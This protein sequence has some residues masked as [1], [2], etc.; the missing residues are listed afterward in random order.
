MKKNRLIYT[1][2][3]TVAA[4]ILSCS[5]AFASQAA[6]DDNFGGYTYPDQYSNCLLL[7]GVDVSAWQGEDVDWGKVKRQGMDY[8]FIRIGY[9]SLDTFKMNE[10]SCFEIN[11]QAARDANMMVG[12]YYYSCATTMDEAQQEAEFVLDTLQERELDLPVVF[13]FEYAGRIKDKYKSKA[14]TTSN[15]LAFLNYIDENSE[16]EPM[17]YSYRNITD[18]TWSP[19]FNVEM[20]DAKYKVWL[21]QYSEDI[22]YSRPMTFWQ[23]TSSGEVKGIDGNVDCNFWFY[24]NDAEVTV[25]GTI[26]IKDAE[27]KLN[28]LDPSQVTYEYTRYSKRPKTTVFYQGVQLTNNVDFK[29]QFVKNVNV[30]TAYVM[31][32][33]IGAY[34][35]TKLV[36]YTITPT[37]IE[38]GIEVSA[39]DPQ[40]FT[41]VPVT[42]D[43]KV[44]YKGTTLKNGV[45]YTLTYENNAAVG[46][47]TVTING[48]RNYTGSYSTTFDIL[49]M[50]AKPVVTGETTI[51]KEY[52]SGP[53]PLGLTTTS[54]GAVTYTSSNPAI[55]A[56]GPDGTVTL[57]GAIGS[58]VLTMSTEANAE[59]YASTTNVTLNVTKLVNEITGIE[60]AYT[61]LTDAQPFTLG[62]VHKSTSPMTFT[63]SNPAVAA[64]D[65]AGLITVTGPG[66][67]ELTYSVA[68]DAGYLAASKTVIL[69]VNRTKAEIIQCIQASTIKVSSKAAYGK[70]TLTWKKTGEE[71]VD[72]YQ[73]FRTKKK[74]QFYKTAFGKT[75]D[76]ATLTF[77]N[78][79]QLVK[80]TR[81]YY[82][83][84]G[85]K[86]IDG[87][88]YYTKWSN[89]ANRKYTYT[90]SNDIKIINGIK[91]TTVKATSSRGKGYIKINWKKTGNY[92][93]DYYQICRSTTKDF[94]KN[95]VY[96][97]T[98]SG[99][100]LTNKHTKNL[101]KGKRYYYKVRGV[102]V[103]DGKKRFTQW[104]NVVTRIAK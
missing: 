6:V 41:G 77:V 89:V 45:D 35:N 91:A 32:Q 79:K 65:A 100:V 23:Y 39:I 85:V 15:I 51:N 19:K 12:V 73:V 21:A 44:S 50:Q 29:L 83:V 52:I 42:V 9:T 20:I 2:L 81:Y 34:S 26:N 54:N 17:F 30:G 61:V 98:K 49:K 27:V 3:L 56:I 92:K 46:T 84:R 57:T 48:M 74:G 31:V 67:T 62:A 78:D 40:R 8:A 99:K 4:L 69:T 5:A 1:L 68:E 95:K 66:Q 13:D 87:K 36:P 7:D 88:K 25:D 82:K 71:D 22:G 11:Y 94:S 60:P 24:N 37:D 70:V 58:V 76:A 64:I 10:D 90:G 16:Y 96:T 72:F 97:K 80:N 53:F 55:A 28:G 43:P 75:A 102:R 86:V 103:V 33:G 63:S 18:P 14:E 59:F 101:K 104:S 38:A 93:V 47:A